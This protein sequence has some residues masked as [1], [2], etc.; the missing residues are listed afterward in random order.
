[1]K[2]FLY[3][4]AIFFFIINFAH[5]QDQLV[6]THIPFAD[7]NEFVDM[8]FNQHTYEPDY[9]VNKVPG[10]YSA[11]DWQQVI[12]SYWGTGLPTSE[13]L[14]IF[15]R[16]YGLV[17]SAYACFHDITDN[18]LALKNQ[19]RQEVASGVSKGRF[20]AIMSILSLSLEEA[21]T[22]A[23]DNSVLS[24]LRVPGTPI[25]EIGGWGPT[26]GYFGAGLTPLP[27]STL[28]VYQVAPNH[29][30]GLQPGDRVIGY[31]GMPWKVLVFQLLSYDF[32]IKGIWGSSPN[33]RLHSLLMAAGQNWQLFDTID[34][35]KFG[36][37][38]TI[39]LPTSLL[40]NQSMSLFATEQMDIPG[41]PKPNYSAGEY[42]SY[43]IITGTNIGYI[44]GWQ[45]SGNAGT[46]FLN[47]VNSLMN[48]DGMIIDF[49]TNFGGNMFLSDSALKKLFTSEY[50]TIDFGRR[51]SP[52]NH[53]SMVA[54]NV[55]AN[56]K[57]KG[58]PPG[59]LNPIAVLTGPGA[60]SSGDQVALRMKYH[61]RAKFFGK[62]TN[63]AFNSPSVFSIH[64]DWHV[65][66]ATADAYE[67]STPGRY[68]THLEF[69]VD[70][71]VWLTPDMVAQGKD[72]VVE[73][74]VSWIN[75]FY[76]SSTTLL[77][78]NAE[79]GIGKWTVTSKGWAV[80]NTNSHSPVNSFTDSPSGNYA[81]NSDNSLTLKTAVNTSG[82]SA[83]VLSFWHKYAT[84]LDKD[85]CRIEVSSNNGSTWQEAVK[86]S[87]TVSTI[88]EV[89][90]DIT[91]YCSN[92]S[93]VKVRFRLTS[94]ASTHLD[95]WYV[96]D[97]LITKYTGSNRP[98]GNNNEQDN[99]GMSY[100]LGQNFPNPFNPVTK[101]S[102]QIPGSSHV[103]LNI[104]D[105]T[106]RLVKTLVNEVRDEGVHSITFDGSGLSSGTYFYRLQAGDFVQIKKMVLIK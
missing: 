94:D 58:T 69:P 60:V 11:A 65:A 37:A 55:S 2:T 99:M 26:A 53:L 22:K 24:T 86:Y 84:Q 51:S 19:Y 36:S 25:L 68:L 96:D 98:V 72:D 89:K 18:W 71:S 56:Y 87:G 4:L 54:N 80:K 93:Q 7:M 3:F 23:R 64:S 67:M 104:Y 103:T 43:G 78:D 40:S 76:G 102:Y 75:T 48:T 34:I 10:N 81:K 85:F 61:P 79:G 1:M 57:V 42:V 39:H 9:P 29:P 27:D 66:V 45:W 30:L 106:G 70:Q 41:V 105:I 74:A 13:K 12:D 46:Q 44:Y 16:F 88:H 8:T 100:S 50:T 95:G 82:S 101:I 90:L 59:Y 92:S 73:S 31:D 52:T 21:H 97:I 62:T 6:Q 14:R 35:V 83:I 77:T 5:S 91:K 32:P 33:S 17:D 15:D 20:A 38:D 47:A 49:R 28:L 63:T